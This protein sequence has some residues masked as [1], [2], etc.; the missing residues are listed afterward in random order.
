VA[1]LSGS[2][3]LAAQLNRTSLLDDQ[4]REETIRNAQSGIE[5][6]LSKNATSFSGPGEIDLFGR[7]ADSVFLERKTWGAFELLVSRAHRRHFS[8]QVVALAGWQSPP[9]DRT[10]LVLADLDR[11]LSITGHTELRGDCFLPRAG[12][13][14]AYIEGQSYN[15]NELVYGQQ[16]ISERYLPACNDTLVRQI[17]KLFT[18]TG[19]A[20]DSILPLAQF[21]LA[22]SVSNS[23]LGKPIFILSPG[24]IRIDHQQVTGQVCIISKSKI[25]IGRNCHISQA[26]LLAPQILVEENAEGDFQAFAR[27]SL[28]IGRKARLHYPSVLALVA[29]SQSPDRATLH[30]GEKSMLFGELFAT[31]TGKD[32]RKTV[33]IRQDRDAL[34]YGTIYSSQLADLPG[35][36]YG[37]VIVSRFELRTAS[38][39]YENHLLDA[40]IDRNRRLPAYAASS[41]ALKNNEYKAVIEWLE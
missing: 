20:G 12:I 34:V 18:Y 30:L 13:R 3:L 36:T 23:F 4:A 14:R 16:K 25:I 19:T 38:A 21:L 29:G 31:G 22:D 24:P 15:G 17:E 7:G 27:D 6:L 28:E 41:L 32:L 39:V 1:L 11:P 26:I 2:L 33:C 5:F 10:A 37:T 9:E 35:K 40:V 8:H